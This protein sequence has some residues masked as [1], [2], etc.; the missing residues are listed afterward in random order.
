MLRH[1]Y[2]YQLLEFTE[3]KIVKFPE[4]VYLISKYTGCPHGNALI[5]HV[6]C[7]ETMGPRDLRFAV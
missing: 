2:S 1:H 6:N 5:S 4:P 7:T 3:V